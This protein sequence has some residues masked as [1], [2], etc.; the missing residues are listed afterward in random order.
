M[1]QAFAFT[2]FPSKCS[3]VDLMIIDIP[4]DLPIPELSNPPT[5]VPLGNKH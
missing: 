5:F 4:D 1:D 3:V 2:T